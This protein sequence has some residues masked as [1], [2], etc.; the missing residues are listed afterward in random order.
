MFGHLLERVLE[1]LLAHGCERL[2]RARQLLSL[3]EPVRLVMVRAHLVRSVVVLAQLVPARLRLLRA[4]GNGVP[5]RKVR[6]MLQVHGVIVPDLPEPDQIQDGP[7]RWRGS[8]VRPQ[9]QDGRGLQRVQALYARERV[10][11][12]DQEPGER[13]RCRGPEAHQAGLG[14]SAQ[15]L[16]GDGRQE[17]DLQ[18][19]LLHRGQEVGAQGGDPGRGRR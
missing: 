10:K 19:D 14:G 8:P 3:L 17:Q 15:D 4:E 9:V 1:F 12:Q 11:G 5:H 2:H 13:R 16:G 18:E 7:L 6:V